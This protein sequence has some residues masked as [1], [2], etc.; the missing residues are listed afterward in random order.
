MINGIG[1]LR[2]VGGNVVG[3]SLIEL[4]VVIAIIAGLAALLLLA[5]KAAPK[6]GD[7]AACL[8]NQRQ[9]YVAALPPGSNWWADRYGTTINWEWR[10][11]SYPFCATQSVG[12][13]PRESWTDNPEDRPFEFQINHYK[14]IK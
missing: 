13:V 10:P 3:F 1:R 4:R 6:S 8:N 9:I 7:R 5:L 14:S 2:Y 11:L 12:L